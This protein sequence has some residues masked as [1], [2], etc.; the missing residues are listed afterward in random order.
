MNER[1]KY[2]PHQSYNSFLP[3]LVVIS[4]ILHIGW[5]Y[6]LCQNVFGGA[7]ITCV[8]AITGTYV[9]ASL[10]VS[11]KIYLI[12]DS[13]GIEINDKYN[14]SQYVP[15][16]Q[17]KYG[18]HARSYKGF[19]F[20]LLSNTFLN[21]HQRKNLANQ[22]ANS[23]RVYIDGTVVFYLNNYRDVSEIEELVNEYVLLD[24]HK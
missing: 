23:S 18:Y 2:Y 20:L 15:W 13:G 3:I 4:V 5:I 8:M 14:N 1:V 7:C 21:E 6:L 22:S 24:Q 10:Y 9:C 11:S 17:L 12:F 19:T 16:E